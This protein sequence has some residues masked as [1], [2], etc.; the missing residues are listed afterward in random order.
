MKSRQEY[1]KDYLEEKA[2][3]VGDS[4]ARTGLEPF[5]S[6]K[7][8]YTEVTYEHR[9]THVTVPVEVADAMAELAIAE[10]ENSTQEGTTM[11]DTETAVE[12]TDPSNV[13]AQ[14]STK[15]AGP[16]QPS[17]TT[18]VKKDAGPSKAQL[19]QTVF[20]DNYPAVVAGTLARKDIITMFQAPEIGLTA[21]GASTYYQKF[22]TKAD[23]P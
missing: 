10:S 4:S 3:V 20:D 2:M 9:Q 13:P 7:D 1:M 12:A 16:K 19:A 18:T 17:A 15:K 6:F 5:P 21:A 14:T 11:S 22:K 23:K 8:W